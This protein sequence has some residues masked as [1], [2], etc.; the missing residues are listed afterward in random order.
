MDWARDVYRVAIMKMLKSLATG[1]SFDQV[2]IMDSDIFSMRRDISNW[3]PAPPSTVLTQSTLVVNRE[4]YSP[5]SSVEEQTMLDIRIPN[6]KLGSVRPASSAK[7]RFVC[8]Y[9]T[10]TLIPSFLQV[11]G[12]RQYSESK[13][14]KAARAIIKF[15]TQFDEVLVMSKADLDLL[16]MLWTDA[17]VPTDPDTNS[18]DFYVFMEASWYFSSSWEITREVSCLAVTKSAFDILKRY[19][20][21]IVRHKGVES[22]PKCERYCSSR[23]IREFIGCLRSGSPWQ[24]LLATISC[25]L[26]TI[27]PLPRR[28]REDFT[29]PVDVL[30]LGYTHFDRVKSF[31]MKYL[32]LELWKPRKHTIIPYRE[33]NRLLK[34]GYKRD[35]IFNMKRE[36][37]PKHT[38]KSWKRISETLYTLKD[39]PHDRSRCGRC[40][41]S[42]GSNISPFAH[43]F[44][45]TRNQPVLSDYNAIL[46]VS[47]QCNSHEVYT[48][49]SCVFALGRVHELDDNIGLAAMIGDLIQDKPIYHTLK[50]DV[51]YPTSCFDMYNLPLPYRSVTSE[52]EL[53]LKNWIQEL[54][55][56]NFQVQK[57]DEL[58]DKRYEWYFTR[59]LMYL[60]RTGHTEQEAAL[61][62]TRKSADQYEDVGSKME[63]ENR[64]ESEKFESFL[65]F[66]KVDL[67][68]EVPAQR[69]S[70]WIDGSVFLKREYP[71]QFD[72]IEFWNMQVSSP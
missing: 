57:E 11:I 29:P 20:K 34:K 23:A 35:D 61:F 70:S 51:D 18:D 66:K 17:A 10:E 6:T 62:M 41:K 72:Y 71:I 50:S 7:F 46:V 37:P 27:Y 26:V 47:L 58:R 3:V 24:V 45:D 60:L 16:E 1:Q 48:P 8:L 40:V 39:E 53:R 38:D 14:E 65:S 25:T 31:I 59:A 69:Y 55:D 54:Q 63:R 36:R 56:E 13:T 15:I 67:R 2:S 49:D 21:F 4:H 52:E 5:S 12:G 42:P 9:L 19:A 64:S 32:K 33:L 30:G 68:G 22:L 44:L 43:G 28:R